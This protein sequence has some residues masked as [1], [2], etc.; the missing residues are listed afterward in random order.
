[1]R[2]IPFVDWCRGQEDGGQV[3]N[4]ANDICENTRKMYEE[5]S[6]ETG[7]SGKFSQKQPNKR[8]YR[9]YGLSLGMVVRA[10]GQ[11]P[12]AVLLKLSTKAGLRGLTMPNGVL[13]H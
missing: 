3:N 13:R 7:F 9:M 4:T 1:M 12:S 8:R 11:V 5:V 10:K 6:D 2:R